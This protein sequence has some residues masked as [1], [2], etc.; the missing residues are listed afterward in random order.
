MQ[1]KRGFTLVELLV[2]IA[3][4]GVLVALL[5]PA[6]QSAREAARRIQCTNHLKQMVLAAMS[7][8]SALRILP[9]G[10]E[11]AWRAR[12]FNEDGR[13]A[14]APHQDWS[15]HYQILPYIEDA[16]VWSMES[17]A[18][19]K[20]AAISIFFCPTRR[21]PQ[22]VENRALTCYAGNGGANSFGNNNWGRLGN[23]L[24]GV[25]VRRPNGTSERSTSVQT[26]RQM[27]DGSSKT[28]FAAEKCLNV[29]LLGK[30]QT[31]DDSGYWDGW[32]WDTIRW[33][34]FQPSKDWIDA[35]PNAAHRGNVPLHGAFGGSHPTG[36]TAASAD[37]SVRIVSFSVD[38]NVFRLYSSRDDEQ[39]FELDSLR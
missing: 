4:I 26:G 31:D 23:G 22:W 15:W 33:G 19:A 37:G 30:H 13:P 32:D 9:D 14:I 8:E 27:T 28:M 1:H 7:H 16:A 24:D 36:F 5:L 25:L 18:Q 35:D 20:A 3:I 17:D 21:G 11:G 6:V 12:T 34:Y 2:V 29:G 38:L 10:G 39:V